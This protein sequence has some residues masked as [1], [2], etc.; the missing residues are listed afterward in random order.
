M[1]SIR[2]H[3]EQN[4]FTALGSLKKICQTYFKIGL[5]YF[6]ISQTYFGIVNYAFTGNRDKDDV[7]CLAHASKN[8]TIMKR[9]YSLLVILIL[10]QSLSAAVITI[11]ADAPSTVAVGEEFSLKYIVSTRDV[12]NF[13]GPKFP[14]TIKVL[15]GVGRSEMSSYQM[16]NGKSSSISSVTFTYTLSAEK[17]GKLTIPPAVIKVKGKDYKTRTVTIQVVNAPS[18]NSSQ[19]SQGSAAGTVSHAGKITGKDLFIVVSSNKKTVYEQEPIL[20]TYKIYTRVNL[21]Q[22]TGDMPDLKGFLI[23][24]VP[25]PQQRQLK[26]EQYN[27]ENYNSTVWC[28]YVMFPQQSGKLEIPSIKFDGVV[29]VA[30]PNIDPFDAFFNGNTNFAEVKKTIVAP[31]LSINVK[32]LPSPKPADFS[33]AVG[34]FEIKS[35]VLTKTP[36]T[37]DNLSIRVTISGV[38]NMKLITAPK[39]NLGSDFD[40]YTPK[41]TEKTELTAEGIKGTINYDYVVVPRQKGNY[42]L[43]IIKFG[44]FDISENRY[45]TVETVPIDFK[46]EQGANAAVSSEE[47]VSG[48]IRDIHRGSYSV[49]SGFFDVR[50]TTYY[51]LY[52]FGLIVFVA[53]FAYLKRSEHFKNNISLLLRKKA[54]R[55]AYNNLKQAESLMKLNKTSEFYDELTN[56]LQKYISN[57]FSIPMSEFKIEQVQDKLQEQG[58]AKELITEFSDVMSQCE[59]ARFAP[60]DPHENMENLFRRASEIITK[61]E[62]SLK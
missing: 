11:K 14:S 25:V 18:G 58:I 61:I 41:R 27:G 34:K 12:D 24:E 10:S 31:S 46:V 56:A 4:F 3:S 62:N 9:I 48:D 59:F 57:R 19:S 29:A 32:K 50:N 33:G 52:L 36:R 30:N 8:G 55:L 1:D 5:T 28:Q 44:Y 42:T 26:I 20:L 40:V 54:K 2:R 51:L 23:Q 43:P 60:R 37:N 35:A 53:L 47:F 21:T 38:G 13:E 39:L 16:I 7:C 6:K 22:M 15:Y 45:E 49:A 17:T